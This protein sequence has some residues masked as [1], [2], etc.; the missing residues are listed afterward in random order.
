MTSKKTGRIAALIAVIIIAVSALA[1]C[2]G[3]MNDPAISYKELFIKKGW[4]TYAVSQTKT[5]YLLYLTNSESAANLTDYPAIWSYSPAADGVTI[6]QVIMDEILTSQKR[7]LFFADYAKEH[8]ITLSDSE[9]SELKSTI[10][11][12]IKTNFGSVSVFESFLKEY[13]INYDQLMEYSYFQSLASKGQEAYFSDSGEDPITEETMKSY[14]ELKY[15]TASHILINNVTEKGTSDKLSA[16]DAAAKKKQAEEIYDKITS[17]EDFD[18]FLSLTDEPV[19]STDKST[20][21]FSSYELNFDDYVSAVSQMKIGDVKKI[22]TEGGIYIIKRK[23]L[24]ASKFD[25][26][27]ENISYVLIQERSEALIEKHKSEFTESGSVLS[28]ISVAEAP[29][30]K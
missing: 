1:S 13:G 3:D 16:E 17:G 25:S 14:F 4:L 7:M 15:C 11:D 20:V 5:S 28:K 24:D 8:G 6:G 29:I 22:E 23:E 30:F 27:K 9:K 2:A 19:E 18:S 26:Y 12:S 10:D 21:T